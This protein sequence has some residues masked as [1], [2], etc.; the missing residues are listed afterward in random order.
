MSQRAFQFGYLQAALIGVLLAFGSERA[1]A[2]LTVCNKAGVKMIVAVAYVPKDAPGV[3]T[4]GDL[5]TKVDGWFR[6][7]PGECA[8]VLDIDAGGHWVSVYAESRPAGQVMSGNEPR[9]CVQGGSFGEH[10]RAGSECRSGWRSVGFHRINTEK[11][12]HTFTIR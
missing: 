12:N 2:S 10:Q 1:M 3:S 6:F 7:E 8:Q 11:R 9:F 5:A 4:G